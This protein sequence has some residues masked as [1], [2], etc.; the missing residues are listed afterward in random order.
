MPFLP[1]NQQ[2]QST[3]SQIHGCI[4]I[5]ICSTLLYIWSFISII[6][7]IYLAVHRATNHST[8][9]FC[10][11]CSCCRFQSYNCVGDSKNLWI[12]YWLHKAEKQ[13][14]YQNKNTQDGRWKMFNNYQA[15]RQCAGLILF[16][17]LAL[18]ILFAYLHRMLPHLY[19]FL[20]FFL[21][22]IFLWEQSRS[23]S[24]LYVVKGA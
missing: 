9:L 12:F 6:N 2:R 10:E 13:N 5:V 17:I 8:T 1:P 7:I 18:Y 14:I 22:Y 19:F 21:N 3:E 20:H 24:R 4:Y 16:L 15:A 11:W 23:V